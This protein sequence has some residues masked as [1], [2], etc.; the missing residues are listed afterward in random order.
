LG[1][2]DV[3]A[4]ALQMPLDLDLEG[5]YDVAVRCSPT[6]NQIEICLRGYTV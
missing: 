4:S 6:V 2:L 1:K 5:V 3:V